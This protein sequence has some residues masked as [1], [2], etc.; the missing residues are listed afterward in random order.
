M[1]QGARYTVP[2]V[3][4]ETWKRYPFSSVHRNIVAC[5]Y[6]TV[7]P[8][9]LYSISKSS[10]SFIQR[11][12]KYKVLDGHTGCVNTVAWN[13]HGSLLLTGS[14]DYLLNIYDTATT[15]LLHSVESG[16]RT[17]VFSAKFLPCTSDLKVQYSIMFIGILLLFC[18]VLYINVVKTS[19]EEYHMRK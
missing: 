10:K 4:D 7:R 3:M 18:F 6:G 9:D 16:H 5:Q 11:L 2:T 15:K 14:D 8:W 13:D 1:E 17:N 12:K 19:S